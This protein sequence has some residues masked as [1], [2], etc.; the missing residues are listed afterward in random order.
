MPVGG[1]IYTLETSKVEIRVGFNST[2]SLTAPQRISRSHSRNVMMLNMWNGDREVYDFARSSK[3]MV[4]KGMEWGTDACTR[5]DCVRLMGR[6]GYRVGITGLNDDNLDTW[7]HI[8]SFGW[9]KHSE[10]PLVY[11]WILELEFDDM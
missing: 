5:I 6:N 7:F 8:R 9:K 4:L 2:C 3:N 1:D 11:A 10:C